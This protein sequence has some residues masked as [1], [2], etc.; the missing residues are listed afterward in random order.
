MRPKSMCKCLLVGV[1]LLKHLGREN[2]W[3][4]EESSTSVLKKYYRQYGYRRANSYR[5]DDIGT[6]E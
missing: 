2:H 5:I 6:G 3:F 4:Q 1:E